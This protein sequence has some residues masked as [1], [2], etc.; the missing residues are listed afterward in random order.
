M[1]PDQK[2]MEL[3]QKILLPYKN[4]LTPNGMWGILWYY[5]FDY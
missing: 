3:R 5:Y 2:I 4:L 1:V